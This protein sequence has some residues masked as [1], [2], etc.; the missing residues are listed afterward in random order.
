MS[1]DGPAGGILGK[2]RVPPQ[3]AAAK[4][5]SMTPPVRAEATV[6]VPGSQRASEVAR[7][8]HHQKLLG[9]GS[10]KTCTRV[11][12][13]GIDAGSWGFSERCDG[14]LKPREG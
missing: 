9:G 5:G 8:E 10:T 3:Q 13:Q 4:Y 2:G 14:N 1:Q 7:P 12:A 11:K 6:V